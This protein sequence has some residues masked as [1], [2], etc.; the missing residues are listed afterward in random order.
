ML[1]QLRQHRSHRHHLQHPAYQH[2]PALFPTATNM[3]KQYLA[4]TAASSQ[5]TMALPQHNSTLGTPSSAHLVK[6]ATPRSSQVTII[7]YVSLSFV[8]WFFYGFLT[9]PHI[10]WH[11][12]RNNH[13][14]L[15]SPHPNRHIS[16]MHKD[17]RSNLWRLL[18]QVRERQR[19]HDCTAIYMEPCSRF[20]RSEL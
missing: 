2:N 15:S 9:Y 13:N 1:H 8:L 19:H 16:Q 6:T 17:C 20:L 10:G 4:T 3:L 14:N 18:Q 7:A 5:V 11:F 12:E